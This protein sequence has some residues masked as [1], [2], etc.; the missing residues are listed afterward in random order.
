MLLLVETAL[1][2]RG[3]GV[4]ASLVLRRGLAGL[5]LVAAE[6]GPGRA[7]FTTSPLPILLF[8]IRRASSFLSLH[9]T[10]Q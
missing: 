5:E 4:G 10:A 7:G 1:M 8:F 6:R 9:V 3:E 2:E